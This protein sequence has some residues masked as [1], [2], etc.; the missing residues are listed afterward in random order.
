M[1][2]PQDPRDPTDHLAT[3][4]LQALT[5]NPETKA[6]ADPPAHPAQ[7]APQETKAPL[8]TPAR[9]LE[10]SQAPLARPDLLANQAPLVP[11][12]DPE[13]LARTATPVPPARP[14]MLVPLAVLARL[15]ALVAP[16]TPARTAHL[17]A[18][19]TAHRLV[20]LQ[21]IKHRQLVDRPPSSHHLASL[22]G[23]TGFI[24]FS[25]FSHVPC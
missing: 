14:E 21:D 24:A 1:P 12:A 6:H 23:V 19:T 16:E 2:A 10:P 25:I 11:Q 4:E 17:A 18:A 9:L 5:A 22:F 20:W 15:A 13:M 7:L 3:L 8:E